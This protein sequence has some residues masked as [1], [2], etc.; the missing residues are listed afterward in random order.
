M[1]TRGIIV[2][3]RVINIT[4][5]LIVIVTAV[6]AVSVVARLSTRRTVINGHDL[7]CNV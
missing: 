1:D 5:L 6:T 3:Y 7:Q 4:V 2:R